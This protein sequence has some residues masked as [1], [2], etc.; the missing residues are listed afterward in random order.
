MHL[1]VVYPDAQEPGAIGIDSRGNPTPSASIFARGS[2][3]GFGTLK[4]SPN[5]TDSYEETENE[6]LLDNGEVGVERRLY[7][8]DLIARFGHHLAL[9][10]N[11]GEENGW[12]DRGKDS[13]GNSGWPNSHEQRQA[14][15][16]YRLRE[17][18]A[19][20]VLDQ[21][22]RGAPGCGLPQLIGGLPWVQEAGSHNTIGNTL[23]LLQTLLF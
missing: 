20:W 10:W 21:R 16:D 23:L 4:Y 13:T 11:L 15:A 6:M 19:G 7:Y 3:S 1:L 2:I 12:D 22:R 9:N 14:F 17:T 8:R 18:P 5:T